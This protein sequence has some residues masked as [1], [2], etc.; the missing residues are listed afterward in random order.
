MV[1]QK[2]VSGI[3]RGVLAR[4]QTN[5]FVYLDDILLVARRSKVKRGCSPPTHPNSSLEA[6][7]RGKGAYTG[8][9]QSPGVLGLC[10]RKQLCGGLADNAVECCGMDMI[11]MRLGCKFPFGV[12]P[13]LTDLISNAVWGECLEL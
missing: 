9:L 5:G 12:L 10:W 3:V 13:V 2:L 6:T 1:C 11:Q 8:L 4:L 7:L